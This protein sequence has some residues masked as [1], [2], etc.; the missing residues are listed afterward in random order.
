MKIRQNLA[1]FTSEHLVM[2]FAEIGIE[3][4]NAL[5]RNEIGSFNK[6][7]DEKA[8]ILAELKSREGDQRTLLLRLYSHPNMQV[9]LNAAK[10]TLAIE[11]NE[12]R[13]QLEAIAAS[14][15]GPQAGDAGMSLW[16]LDEGIF[17][18]T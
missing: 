9:R 6:L 4:D 10:A 1:R 17:K 15:Q 12:A 8:A 18:P 2:R 5:L 16:T 13:K 11:P 7:Y 3:Q 14:G